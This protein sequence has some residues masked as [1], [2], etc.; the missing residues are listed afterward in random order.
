MQ[1]TL[2]I[3]YKDASHRLYLAEVERVKVLDT[4]ER[5]FKS[6]DD[7]LN[8]TLEELNERYNRCAGIP[9]G[10]K[11]RHH[12]CSDFPYVSAAADADADA[13]TDMN[14]RNN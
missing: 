6:L 8:K 4:S 11:L 5:E 1:Q 13:D 3:S 9:E 12:K 2:G 14:A 10:S 7:R